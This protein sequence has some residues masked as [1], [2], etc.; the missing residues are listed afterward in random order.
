MSHYRPFL[1]L[2]VE[3]PYFA[4]GNARDLQF[5][6]SMASRYWLEQNKALVKSSASGLNIFMDHQQLEEFDDLSLQDECRLE[7]KIFSRDKCFHNYT[8][9]SI[10]AELATSYDEIELDETTTQQTITPSRW[11]THHQLM[12]LV[13]SQQIAALP[14]QQ[15]SRNL[16]GYL[17]IKVAKNTVATLSASITLHYQPRQAFWSYYFLADYVDEHCAVIDSQQ[18]LTFDN[19]GRQ[20]LSNGQWATL[21]RSQQPLTVAQYSSYHFQL[22]KVDQSLIKCLPCASPA[23]LKYDQIEGSLIHHYV[24]YVT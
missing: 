16:V 3:H 22:K 19:H 17:K 18:Q 23:Q 7:L 13:Q 8:E 9:S 10:H 20:Q 12:E 11:L 6:W 1:T 5:E 24:I 4:D 15:L 21:F 14:E 2:R